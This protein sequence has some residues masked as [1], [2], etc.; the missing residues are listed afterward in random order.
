MNYFHD[1]YKKR[2]HDLVDL[3][4]N[5]I[6]CGFVGRRWANSDAPLVKGVRY[7]PRW[8]PCI[9][10]FSAP[11]FFCRV[12]HRSYVTRPQTMCIGIPIWTYAQTPEYAKSKTSLS[13]DLH[14]ELASDQMPIGAWPIT[15]GSSFCLL[16]DLREAVPT[17]RRKSNDNDKGV[18]I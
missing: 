15:N 10:R 17:R 4:A 13:R 6:K 1:I 8:E 11:R 9:Y 18:S 5:E 7:E 12:C 2:P 16:Y 14:L 3:G